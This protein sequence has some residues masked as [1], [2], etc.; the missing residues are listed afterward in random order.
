MSTLSSFNPLDGTLVGKVTVTPMEEIPDLVQEARSAQA[1]WMALGLGGRAEIL[2][3]S[4][5]QFGKRA[6][7]LGALIT[8]EMGK[9]LSESIPEARTIGSGMKGE[10]AEIVEALQPETFRQG[11]IEST[12][13]QDPFGVCAAITPWNFPMAMPNWMVLPALAAGN[14]VLFKPS[15]ETPLCGQAYAEILG[16]HLP[17]GVLTVVHGDDEQG[18]ALVNSDVDL[19]AFTGSREVGKHILKTASD[20]LKRVILELGG[21]D[22]MIVLDDADLDEAAKFA[23]WNGFRNAGQVCVSTERI[24]VHRQVF[25]EF[26]ERLAAEAEGLVIGDGLADGTSVGPMVNDTQRLHVLE[27][28]DEA[29][30]GGARSITGDDHDQAPFIKPTVLANVDEDLCIAKDETFGPV[31]CLTPVDSDDEAV[32]KANA[33]PFGLGAVV[34]GGDPQRANKVGRRLSAGM[35]GINRG[36]GGIKGT[37]WVGAA[38]SGYGFHK[39]RDGHRQ[40]TQ[41]RVLSSAGA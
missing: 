20:G 1:G 3:R 30:A 21:K 13:H 36:C 10:L 29:L 35:I 6:K 9:P 27:Q 17:P 18:K 41:A 24:Y 12:V 40:F 4:G 33:T 16:E 5:P 14:T 19:I 22:P 15:E 7:E 11:S 39:G 8:R 28:I 37:P 2:A 32:A 25:D 26:Q 34:F 31:V 23:A 38:E